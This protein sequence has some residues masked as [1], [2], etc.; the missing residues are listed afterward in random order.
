MK[1]L[2]SLLIKTIGADDSRASHRRK[3]RGVTASS[4]NYSE[5][6]KWACKHKQSFVNFPIDRSKLTCQIHEN[7]NFSEQCKFLNNFGTMY[8]ASGT[9]K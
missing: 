1:V 6:G 5:V 8:D 4:K 3:M 7:G 9:F 2:Y